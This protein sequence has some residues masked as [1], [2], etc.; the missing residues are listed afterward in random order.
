M[1]FVLAEIGP[2]QCYNIKL[3][4]KWWIM[5][6][7]Q[8]P[9]SARQPTIF[10]YI[11]RHLAIFQWICRIP[12]NYIQATLTNEMYFWSHCSKVAIFTYKSFAPV[13]FECWFSA[14]NSSVQQYCA[15]IHAPCTLK[16]P[17]FLTNIKM[18]QIW[19]GAPKYYIYWYWKTP[20]KIHL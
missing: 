13:K 1:T 18:S 9:N 10:I 8:G 4:E 7:Y 16:A 6:K 17:P 12:T 5:S 15:S 11:Y 2:N 20:C 14:E 19:H 3:E